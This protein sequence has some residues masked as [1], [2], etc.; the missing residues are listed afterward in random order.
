MF[1]SNLKFL[2]V[3][4][5]CSSEVHLVLSFIDLFATSRAFMEQ[6]AIKSRNENRN[7]SLMEE[8]IIAIN[9]TTMVD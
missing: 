6:T 8:S 3:I 5:F 9:Y 2:D 1:V 4:F 7:A